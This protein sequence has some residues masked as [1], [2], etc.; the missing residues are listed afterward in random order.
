MKV[1]KVEALEKIAND[2]RKN[3]V[4]T[5]Y[6]ARFRSYSEAHCLAQIF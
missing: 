4:K 1:T 3:I 6:T 5:V 2:I